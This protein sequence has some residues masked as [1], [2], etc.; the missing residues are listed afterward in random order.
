M[1]RCASVII[2]ILVLEFAVRFVLD[3]FVPI[4]FRPADWAL[5]NTGKE[6]VRARLS[7]G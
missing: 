3:A 6:D 1:V 4:H 2:K 5:Y 7:R